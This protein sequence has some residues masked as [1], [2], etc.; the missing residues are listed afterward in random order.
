MVRNVTRRDVFAGTEQG[1]RKRLMRGGMLWRELCCLTPKRDRVGKAAD[2]PKHF[3]EMKA[4]VGTLRRLAERAAKAQHRI[5]GSS[6]LLVAAAAREPF[7]GRVC[8]HALSRA[9]SASRSGRG[10]TRYNV[11]PTIV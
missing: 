3:A 4:H 6:F 2:L 8:R 11:R 9:F 5:D 10:V 7:R 1:L